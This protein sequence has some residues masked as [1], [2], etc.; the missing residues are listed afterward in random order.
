MNKKK[1]METLDWY[2]LN[3][4]GYRR[5]NGGFAD[6]TIKEIFK[7]KKGLYKV[8]GYLESGEYDCGDGHSVKYTDTLEELYV[9]NKYN[10][11]TKEEAFKGL[12]K[13]EK[14]KLLEQLE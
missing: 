1:L 9:D 11:L 3:V 4:T 2:F 10:I 6:V 12:S 14:D 13:E 8:E 7:V 5:I